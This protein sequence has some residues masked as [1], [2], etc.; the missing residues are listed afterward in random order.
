MIVVRVGKMRKRNPGS[1]DTCHGREVRY[2]DNQLREGTSAR[3][4]K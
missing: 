4:R 3:A 2:V 1:S